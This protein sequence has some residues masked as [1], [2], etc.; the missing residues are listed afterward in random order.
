MGYRWTGEGKVGPCFDLDTSHGAST[1]SM[2]VVSDIEQVR[3]IW[4]G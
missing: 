1:E 3:R 4:D 2:P